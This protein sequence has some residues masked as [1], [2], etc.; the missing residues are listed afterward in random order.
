MSECDSQANNNSTHLISQI[1]R[2]VECGFCKK[3]VAVKGN[4][5]LHSHGP[6]ASRCP[7]SGNNAQMPAGIIHSSPKISSAANNSLSTQSILQAIDCSRAPLIKRIPRS[8]RIS[9]CNVLSD[10]ME[11]IVNDMGLDSWAKLILA[12]NLCLRLPSGSGHSNSISS[13]KVIKQQISEVL[14]AS[15]GEEL[16]RRA[17]LLQPSGPSSKNKPSMLAK[18]ISSKIDDGDVKGA[19]RLA[20]SDDSIAPPNSDTIATLQL[21]HPPKPADR[22]TFPDPNIQGKS[23]TFNRNDVILAIRSFPS[24]SAGGISG[25]RPQH[26]LDITSSATGESG[27]VFL[28]HLTKLVNLLFS[29]VTL[30]AEIKPII[31]GAKLTALTKKCGGLRPIAVGDTIR[32]LTAKCACAA[33][34]RRAEAIL[35]PKQLGCG[36]RGGVEAAVH[37]ARIVMESGDQHN[38]MIKLDFTNAFNT[39]RR[40]DVAASLASWMPELCSF[41]RSTYEEASIL[42]MG[43]ATIRSEEGLQQGDPLAPIY[44][45]FGIHAHL[46]NLDCPIAIGYLDDVTLI[47][48][49]ENVL[50]NTLSFREAC[51]K[52]GLKLNSSKCELVCQDANT[53][54]SFGANLPGLQRIEASNIELLGAAV[55]ENATSPVLNKLLDGLKTMKAKFSTLDS[56]CAFFLLK[57]CFLMPKFSFLLRSSATF[58]E[59]RLLSEIDA[60][61][62]DLLSSILNVK[63]DTPQWQQAV[64][65]SKMGGLGI[66]SVSLISSSAFLSSLHSSHKLVTEVIGTEAVHPSHK[67]ALEH[68]QSIT[69]SA[70]PADRTKQRNWSMLVYQELRQNLECSLDDPGKSRL[71]G[72]TAPGAA[73]WL[74]CLP[75]SPLGLRLNKCQL[76]IAT[77]LRL[78]APVSE[79]HICVCGSPADGFGFHALTC[80]KSCGRHQRHSQLNQTIH[81]ALRAS[82]IPAILEPVGLARNDGKRPDGMSLTPWQRGKCLIWDATVVNR[83]AGCY[84]NLAHAEGSS[85]AEKAESTKCLKYHELAENYIFEPAAFETL[86]GIGPSTLQFI[87]RLGALLAEKKDDLRQTSFLRQRLAI[88]IQMGNA[89]CV[90]E[91]MRLM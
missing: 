21:K 4:N 5:C 64:L 86:G 88:A 61:I 41:F 14:K 33:V 68:W 49:A 76:R 22:R 38:T 11:S 81:R 20:S 3:L 47:G 58:N 74:K 19:V 16:V 10:A 37:A 8:C 52:I 32:R 30:P 67:D 17:L 26:L 6:R 51:S 50:Q 69:S 24:G 48:K 91:T 12:P 42:K 7:G 54:S 59:T 57:N 80:R 87:G 56:H 83:L 35:R 55:G 72:C 43:N 28:T 13:A 53:F 77:S 78:G 85:V 90:Q 27:V 1:T 23:I 73:D 40:D 29:G 31:F 66:G 34:K 84:S 39:I 18:L 62:R 25:L 15:S 9:F 63:F 44:F 45:C 65:P 70:P 82:G 75:S 2:R 60:T 79:Q 46:S 89:T 71:L 36:T